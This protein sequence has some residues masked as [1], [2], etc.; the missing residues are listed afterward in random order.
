[1]T[2]KGRWSMFDQK[3]NEMQP[4]LDKLRDDLHTLTVCLLDLIQLPVIRNAEPPY[5]ETVPGIEADLKAIIAEDE[6]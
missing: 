1:M 2:L 3:P 5:Q 6:P 4:E